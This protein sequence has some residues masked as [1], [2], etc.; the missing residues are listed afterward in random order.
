M[1]VRPGAWGKPIIRNTK[2]TWKFIKNLDY[3][4]LMHPDFIH[5]CL[6]ANKDKLYLKLKAS[7]SLGLARQL[8]VKRQNNDGSV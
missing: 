5:Y 3:K 4:T 1:K 7:W 6:V 8:L 2:A